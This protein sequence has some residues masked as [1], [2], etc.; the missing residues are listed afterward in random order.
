ML[1]RPELA[2][3]SKV[4]YQAYMTLVAKCQTKQPVTYS[5]QPM[6]QPFENQKQ[7]WPLEPVRFRP[8]SV[9]AAASSGIGHQGS[10]GTG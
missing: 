9:P 5:W 10:N 7:A 2:F 4:G 1:R 3:D 6:A 8:G